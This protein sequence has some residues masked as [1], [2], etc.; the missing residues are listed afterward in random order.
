VSFPPR[1]NIPIDSGH[2]SLFMIQQ[3]TI[4]L[5]GKIGYLPR[6]YPALRSKC[7]VGCIFNSAGLIIALEMPCIVNHH[8]KSIFYKFRN[9]FR[10]LN[11]YFIGQ[12]CCW[13]FVIFYLILN[14]ARLF[15][16]HGGSVIEVF[17]ALS[18]VSAV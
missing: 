17:L 1:N 8:S 14:P 6:P 3:P 11:D 2:I 4:H 12:R 18:S 10:I 5:K 16:L 13:C 9:S 15:I 7:I